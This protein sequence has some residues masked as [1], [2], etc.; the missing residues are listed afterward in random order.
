MDFKRERDGVSRWRWKR[1]GNEIEE[2]AAL[3]VRNS[4]RHVFNNLKIKDFIPKVKNDDEVVE[5][6]RVSICVPPKNALLLTRCRYDPIKM[7]DLTNQ[8]WD[9]SVQ[10]EDNT[11]T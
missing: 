7:A 5:E 10:D 2:E 1:G 8:L 11:N 6:G 4:R 9:S 3:P